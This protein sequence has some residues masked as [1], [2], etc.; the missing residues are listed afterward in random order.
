MLPEATQARRAIWEA[1]NPHTGKRRID[2]AFPRELRATTRE[3]QMLI[4]F[5]NGST[6][7]V[8]GSD[9]FN[10]L[11]GAPPAGVVFSEWALANPAARAYLRPIFAENNGWQMYITTPR[12]KN[13]AFKTF[14]AAKNDPNAFAQKLTAYD[15]GSISVER[16][17][18]E[19]QAYINDYGYD[20]GISL[21]EQEY[22]CSFDA[23]LLGAFYGREMRELREAGRVLKIEYQDVVPVY[24][25]WDLGYSDDTTIWWYQ[26]IRGEVH[27]LECYHAAGKDPDHYFDIVKSKNYRYGMHHFPHDAK[28][29]TFASMG[30]SVQEMAWAALGHD[31]VSIVPSLSVQDGIQAVR[32]MLAVT[33]FDAEKCAS[34]IEALDQ[35]QREWDSEKRMFKDKPLHDWT[36]HYAD[37]FRMMAIAWRDEPKRKED[38]PKRYELDLTFNELIKRQRAK[39]IGAE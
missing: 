29:K 32:K 2:E 10:S 35:Y 17:A 37:S 8:V 22:L 21:F 12:G 3:D 20:Q 30:R 9:N 13:H 31:K 4:R 26:V 5:V 27:V 23:A 15:T 1:I 39:R 34:G 18:A 11:V 33:Y 16:L 7:Q 19:K 25:A 14:E 28:A 6:W 38:D 36:S 24:T